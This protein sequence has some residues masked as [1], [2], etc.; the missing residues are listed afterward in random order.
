VDLLLSSSHQ[1]IGRSSI[2]G[3]SHIV[4]PSIIIGNRELLVETLSDCETIVTRMMMAKYTATH[5]LLGVCVDDDIFMFAI[6][7]MS[8]SY[9]SDPQTRYLEANVT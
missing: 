7:S 2:A 6:Y 9:D 4:W 3:C 1:L 5:C 8:W